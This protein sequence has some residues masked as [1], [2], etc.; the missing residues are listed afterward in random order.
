MKTEKQIGNRP[1]R[2]PVLR[3]AVATLCLTTALCAPALAGPVNVS[4]GGRGISLSVGSTSVGTGGISTGSV[5]GISSGIG[6]ALGGISSG[7]GGTV[8][9]IANGTSGL[10][11]NGASFTGDN[12]FSGGA[13]FGNGAVGGIN[14]RTNRVARDIINGTNITAQGV[15]S[16]TVNRAGG[17]VIAHT[18][19]ANPVSYT[20][21]TLPTIYSV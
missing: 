11:R 12:F 1:N 9:G 8:N 21:L 14:R 10:A 19:K 2:G 20:H 15:T 17:R 18:G 4:V 16:R 3:S 5:G 6:G 7:V 13:S